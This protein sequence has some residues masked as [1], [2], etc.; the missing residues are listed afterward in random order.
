MLMHSLFY[1]CALQLCLKLL[2]TIYE[3]DLFLWN[4]IYSYICL[5]NVSTQIRPPKVWFEYDSDDPQQTPIWIF[6]KKKIGSNECVSKSGG[7]FLHYAWCNISFWWAR[8]RHRRNVVWL[9]RLSSRIF[10]FPMLQ[11]WV[12]VSIEF[13]VFCKLFLSFTECHCECILPKVLVSILGA[14]AIN[15]ASQ[16]FPCIRC[17]H[18]STGLDDYE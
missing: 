10:I 2:A 9:L 6:Y 18:W 7:N 3:L 13:E 12:Y 16:S 8:P 1:S 11:S 14:L 4:F 15:K 17:S 5:W